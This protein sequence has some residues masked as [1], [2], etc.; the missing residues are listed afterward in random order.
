[1]PTPKLH[2]G[3]LFQPPIPETCQE[4][5]Y[6]TLYTTVYLAKEFSCYWLTEERSA[7][8]IKELTLIIGMAWLVD[9]PVSD[10]V[11]AKVLSVNKL[12]LT[13]CSASGAAVICFGR[14]KRYEREVFAP[15]RSV[16]SSITRQ[17]YSLT[18]QDFTLIPTESQ[19]YLQ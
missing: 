7:V 11:W 5:F 17:K 19:L 16:A 4:C 6:T 8:S 14:E 2:Y 13:F 10:G 12:P 9:G 1:M 15:F 18:H 3:A